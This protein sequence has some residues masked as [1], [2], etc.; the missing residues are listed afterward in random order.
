MS[1]V[2]VSESMGSLGIEIGRALAARLGHEFAERD[3][4]TKAAER[5]GQDVAQLSHAAEER[6]TL[7]ERFSPAHARFGQYVE[8]TVYEM[9]ARDNIVLVGLASTIILARAPHTLR[10]RVTAPEPRRA[11][12]VA[13]AAGLTPGAA[14]ERVRESDR[15]RAGRVRFLHHVDWEDPL[16]Y[17]LVINTD[18]IG[19]EEGVRLA[20][21]ALEHD[22]FRSTES[23]RRTLTDLSL[24][25]QAR[26]VLI[27]DPV[28]RARPITVECTDGVVALGGR[29]EEW[30]VRRA[31]EQALARV[32]GIQELRFLAP[33]AIDGEGGRSDE[34]DLHGDA[35]RWG[36]F[37]RDQ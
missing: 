35:H 28:T 11:E 15:E 9:A 21:R 1:V 26:A 36:G 2:A 25:A 7:R 13:Q 17:D 10:V 37:G 30:S 4:I 5:F 3:I 16:V 34:D 18:R 14:L 24:V 12:R 20:E 6:P 19:A 31:A 33:A 29:V 27:A 8:A 32:R 23:S 22:R